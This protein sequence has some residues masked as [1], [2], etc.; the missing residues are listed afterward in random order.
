MNELK[1]LLKTP[2]FWVFILALVLRI[3]RLEE[4]PVGLHVDEIKVG[5][6]ALS[7]LLT[8]KDD[9]LNYFPLYYNS[10][11]DFRPTGIIYL[12]MPSLLFLGKTIFA[13]RFPS[14]LFGALTVIPL[15][16]FIRKISDK[17][18]GL[19]AASILAISPWHLEVSRATSEVAIS[20][21]FAIFAI[22]FFLVLIETKKRIY[23]FASA[24]FTFVS[25]LLYHSIRVLAPLFYIAILIYYL[26]GFKKSKQKIL[27]LSP[28]LFSI[29]AT[30]FF[31]ITSEA[32][33]R[34]G[35]VSILKGEDAN[36]ELGRIRSENLSMTP[37]VYL[38]DNKEVVFGKNFLMQYGQYFGTDFLLGYSAKPYRYRT[39]GTG[40]LMYVDFIFVVFGIY[41]IIKNKKNYLPLLLLI[42]APLPG[43]V[44]IEDTPNL[45]RAFLMVVFIAGVEAYGL[46]RVLK[47]VDKFPKNLG[48]VFTFSLIFLNLL[49]FVHMYFNHSYTHKPFLKD[50][51]VDSPTYRNVGT[52]E[53]SQKLPNLQQKYDKIVIT[54]FP[55]SPYPWYAFFTDRN[56][57]V[58]NET[59][60]DKT[61]ERIYENVI[62]TEQKCPSDNAFQRFKDRNLLVIDSWECPVKEKVKAGLKI[63]IVDQIKRQD[64]SEVYIFLERDLPQPTTIT[65]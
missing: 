45:H 19:I 38:F 30:I 18:T 17:K 48:R 2:L 10:F 65:R 49:F 42:L 13:I 40:L 12:T 14:A 39:P 61:N 60:S 34:F 9:H 50:F 4:F 21:F 51:F 20:A 22:Y 23:A 29:I 64:G 31:G 15:Y 36:Y 52:L 11:G 43:A 41:E 47:I 56:P 28:L 7:I 25:Y 26:K 63:K 3:Y 55:D 58:F 16:F 59:Y 53:L 57:A 6:N 8:G 62:F 54:N 27:L 24:L 46:S 44:T 37:L 35:E 33:Q 1:S 32:R 5:W